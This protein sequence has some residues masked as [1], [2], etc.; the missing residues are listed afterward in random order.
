MFLGKCCFSMI[1]GLE[2]P[3]TYFKT[4][5]FA[6]S[7][8][9]QYAVAT[10]T[11]LTFSLLKIC[12]DQNF[13]YLG[14][15]HIFS[16]LAFFYWFARSLQN[17]WDPGSRIRAPGSGIRPGIRD[18]KSGSQFRMFHNQIVL[19]ILLFQRSYSLLRYQVIMTL[20]NFVLNWSYQSLF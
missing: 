14:H 3:Q 2:H 7:R 17:F 19:F 6:R 8:V 10:C 20:L 12:V 1:W 11:F 5:E 9:V 13:L 15:A 18:P 4:T 16:P